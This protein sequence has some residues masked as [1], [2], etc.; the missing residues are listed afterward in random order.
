M[1]TGSP[2]SAGA[3]RKPATHIAHGK[4][5]GTAGAEAGVTETGVARTHIVR[6]GSRPIRYCPRNAQSPGFGIAPG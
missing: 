3:N 1:R 2:I 5:S 4:S 6:R